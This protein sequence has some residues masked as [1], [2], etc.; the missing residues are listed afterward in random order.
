MKKFYLLLVALLAAVSVN[1]QLTK[2]YM[3]DN[4]GSDW[5]ISSG[6]EM[7]MTES[8][9]FKTGEVEVPSDG[10]YFKFAQRVGSWADVEADNNAY[11]FVPDTKD[12]PA[13]IGTY[14]VT[15]GNNNSW[16]INKGSY[17]FTVDTNKKTLTISDPSSVEPIEPERTGKWIFSGNLLGAWADYEMA[18]NEGTDVWT[19][20]MKDVKSGTQFGLQY[21]AKEGAAAVWYGAQKGMPDVVLDIPMGVVSDN[22]EDFQFKRTPGEYTFSLDAAAMKLTVTMKQEVVPSEFAICSLHGNLFTGASSAF[23][24]RDLTFVDGKWIGTF[25]V[26]YNGPDARFGIKQYAKED[27]SGDVYWCEPSGSADVTLG[28]PMGYKREGIVANG[29]SFSSVGLPLG[30]YEFTIDEQASTITIVPAEEENNI[31]W[32][33]RSNIFSENEEVVDVPIENVNG[34]W[35]CEETPVRNGDLFVVG[36][37]EEGNETIYGCPKGKP[38]ETTFVNVPLNLSISCTAYKFNRYIEDGALG[39][40]KRFRFIFNPDDL[41]IMLLRLEAPMYLVG[42]IA[43]PRWDIQNPACTMTNVDGTNRYH[44][45]EFVY[46]NGYAGGNA[47]FCFTSILSPRQQT[48]DDDLQVLFKEYTN[49]GR[50]SPGVGDIDVTHLNNYQILYNSNDKAFSVATGTSMR[51]VIDLDA[52]Y[53]EFYRPADLLPETMYLHGDLWNHKFDWSGH[54]SAQKQYDNDGNAY[55]EFLGML[56]EDHGDGKGYYVLSDWHKAADAQGVRARAAAEGE[57]AG[58]TDEVAAN[59]H[60]Y[61]KNPMVLLK[62]TYGGTDGLME[63]AP[64]KYYDIKLTLSKNGTVAALTAEESGEITTGVESVEVEDANAAVEYYNM[65]GVRVANPENGMYIRRKGNTVTKVF[66]K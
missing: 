6:R 14:S 51:M 63:V 60:A 13:E 49:I 37:D 62:N 53:S 25:N 16:K 56:I 8:G 15:S 61:T 43:E 3:I 28:T 54:D 1:A 46:F 59:G 4:F 24:D 21:I 45:E 22:K 26:R 23:E 47:Y 65:Q 27:K 32:A 2:L 48:D 29:T 11:V 57:A 44:N 20:T 52:R 19:I 40:K 12:C 34:V 9:V 42:T 36:F 50:F 18:N 30:R 10:C 33:I 39:G 58:L 7:T 55:Y 31:R 41:T 38:A 64:N 5:N 35:Q 17:V 66:V